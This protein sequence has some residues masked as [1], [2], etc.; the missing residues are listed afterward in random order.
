MLLIVNDNKL[1]SPPR[2]L[3]SVPIKVNPRDCVPKDYIRTNIK[4][5]FKL[6]DKWLGKFPMHDTQMY[7]SIRWT[8]YRL[9]RVKCFN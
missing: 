6:I 5:N 7:Y 9:C 8:L 1:P 4:T 2:H 3:F